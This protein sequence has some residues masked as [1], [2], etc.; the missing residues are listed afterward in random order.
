MLVRLVVT[1]DLERSALGRSLERVF[2][3]TGAEVSV[4]VLHK[5]DEL[6]TTRLPD[7][8]VPGT[9]TPTPVRRMANALVTEAVSSA[10]RAQAD[11]VLGVADLELANVLQPQVVVAWVKR[12][13]DEVID[14]RH[15]PAYP[16]QADNHRLR[17]VVRER[18]SF[19]LLVPLAEAY[20]FGEQAALGRAGVA[21][22]VQARRV[23]VDVEAFET[24]DPDFLPLAS[25]RNAAQAERGHGWWRE[26]RHPKRYL[27]FL[28]DRSGGTY[29]EAAGV[30]ALAT[31]DWRG[32][33]A[34]P[35]ATRFARS[36]FQ[37]VADLL[38]IDNP[39]GRGETHACTYAKERR[40]PL[41]LR[42]A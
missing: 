2:Q 40:A 36:L 33:G 17:E 15:P 21:A 10:R 35:E 7:P 12:G 9:R 29:G 18:C 28:V 30:E 32:V 4:E 37:D 14:A 31:L 23:G 16:T 25:A 34:H 11:L 3:S 1:G 42:N 38:E 24:D 13:V 8:S 20:F 41:T 27:E 39:L 26:E 22:R 19:H 6:T 5:L